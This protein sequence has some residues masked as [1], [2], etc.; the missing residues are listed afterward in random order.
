MRQFSA[1]DWLTDLNKMTFFKGYDYPDDPYILAGSCGLEYT[2]DRTGVNSSRDS[3]KSNNGNSGYS[4]NGWNNGK[5]YQ[6]KYSS[7]SPIGGSKLEWHFH[8]C[9]IHICMISL[10][11]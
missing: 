4:T 11:L 6:G 5:S 9:I 7:F 8:T 10:L 3:K 1:A 2:I